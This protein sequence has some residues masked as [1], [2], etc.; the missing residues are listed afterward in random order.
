M[1]IALKNSE[2]K[3]R[4]DPDLKNNATAV[5][6]R[7]GLTVSSAIRLFMEQVVITEGIPFQVRAKKP[8]SML[9]KALEEADEI[10]LNYE[11]VDDML[12]DISPEKE[13]LKQQK[14]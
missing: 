10:K 7:C 5:L 13:K 2:V 11:S 3:S 9:V 6:E 4:I 8:S 14:S 12:E 1:H